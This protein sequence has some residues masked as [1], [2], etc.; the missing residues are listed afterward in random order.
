MAVA[1]ATLRQKRAELRDAEDAAH[2]RHEI[3]RY[4]PRAFGHGLRNCG[5]AA[6]RQRRLEVLAKISRLGRGIST[7]QRAD[8]AWFCAA[9]DEHMLLEHAEGWPLH[10]AE[11]MQGLIQRQERDAAV[12]A[13]SEFM[14]LETRR[15]LQADAVALAL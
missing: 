15:C 7:A 12:A 9:W 10:F 1:N 13:F 2:L 5:G 3:K 11:L 4:E 8:F 14:H 6:A